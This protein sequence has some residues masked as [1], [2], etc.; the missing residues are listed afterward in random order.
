MSYVFMSISRFES[1]MKEGEPAQ[2]SG[3]WGNSSSLRGEQ[4]P[5]FPQ[6]SVT[7]FPAL[8][9]AVVPQLLEGG[10][11]SLPLRTFQ[12]GGFSLCVL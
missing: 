11:H 8:S 7:V 10:K 9:R 2:T 1:W 5:H 12:S 3:T 4:K 6:K